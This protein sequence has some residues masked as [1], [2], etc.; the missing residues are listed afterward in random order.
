[1]Q[2]GVEGGRIDGLCST[3][4]LKYPGFFLLVAIYH[5]RSS[6]SFPLNLQMREESKDW[7]KRFLRARQ[8][9]LTFHFV[10]QSYDQLYYERGWKI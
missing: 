9:L 8:L 4:S 6:G 1:M 5:F 7:C 3:K 10:T 2:I